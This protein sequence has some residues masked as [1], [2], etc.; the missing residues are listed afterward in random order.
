MTDETQA[1]DLANLPEAP[2]SINF[3]FTGKDGRKYQL[4]LRDVD[5][6]R[7]MERLAKLHEA[8]KFSKNGESE[9]ASEKVGDAP[10]ENW[11]SIHNTEM[12]KRE[13][14]DGKGK[15]WYS[16]KDDKDGWCKGFVK[17]V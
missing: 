9:P 4:T 13:P 8:Y 14:K 5:E 11:C 7:L 3:F 17:D 10:R 12:Y 2:A 6:F 1:V 16:H 15:P